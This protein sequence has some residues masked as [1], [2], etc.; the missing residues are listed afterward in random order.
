V[1]LDHLIHCHS[2]WPLHLGSSIT[3]RRLQLSGRHTA[4][5]PQTCAALWGALRALL[6]SQLAVAALNNSSSGRHRMR[7]ARRL[8]L[9]LL[10]QQRI[11]LC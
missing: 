8:L 2:S 6:L 10:L 7:I 9:L 1:L 11:M 5:P 3:S 4:Y